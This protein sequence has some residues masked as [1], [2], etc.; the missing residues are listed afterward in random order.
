M[1]DSANNVAPPS[2]GELVITRVF[3]A[4]RELVW[5][6]WTQPEH[7]RQ[8]SAPHG[9][10]IPVATGDLRPGGA[11]RTCMVSPDG[12]EHWLGGVYREVIPMERL[13]FSHAWD[14]DD[15][16]P[17]HE[18][19]VTVTFADVGERTEMVFRQIGFVS[20]VSREGHAG[21]WGETFERLYA[22]LTGGAFG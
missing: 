13:V 17:G 10:T 18:T 4:P 7:L 14:G 21:G 22:Y 1:A 19:I 9:F 6:A 5:R 12:V 15:G 8:W 3:D 16:R 2:A 20:D 11:F